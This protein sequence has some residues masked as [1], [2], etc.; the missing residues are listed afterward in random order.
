MTQLLELR[1][2]IESLLNDASTMRIPINWMIVELA[3]K[4]YCDSKKIPYIT[5]Q[6]FQDIARKEASIKEEEE[7]KNALYYFHSRG[8]LL[9][10]YEVPKMSNYVIVKQRW[11]YDQL[12][13]LVA[14]SPENPLSGNGVLLKSELPKIKMEGSIKMEHLVSLLDYKKILASYTIDNKVH[15]YL[16]FALPYCQKYHDKFKFLLLESLLIRFSSGFLPRGFFCSLVVSFLQKMPDG[17]ISS[18]HMNTIQQFRNVMT[19][20]LPNDLFLRLQ[21]KIHYLEI[22]VRHHQH[23]KPV[24]SMLKELEIL[25][26]YV[27]NVCEIL[28]LDCNILVFFVSMVNGMKKNTCLKCYLNRHCVA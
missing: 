10:F 13:M 21:D 26:K 1:D 20:L 11:L 17:W 25:C 14:D 15:Y 3:V 28:K 19:F 9:N 12:S 8:I 16:P 27:F 5:Y 7:A 24:E 18:L 6:E 2:K 4:L 22:Q 23:C